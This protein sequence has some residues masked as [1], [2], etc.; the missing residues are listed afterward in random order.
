MGEVFASP[1]DLNVE[2]GEIEQPLKPMLRIATPVYDSAGR[3]RGIVLV[4]FFGQKVLERLA[5]AYEG[6]G[7]VLLLSGDGYFL[8]GYTAADEWRFMHPDQRGGT[9][10]DRYPEL[11]LQVQAADRGSGRADAGLFS[12][13]TLRPVP[14]ADTSSCRIRAGVCA[15][16]CDLR[17]R[18]VRLPDAPGQF[19]GGETVE[20]PLFR[21]PVHRPLPVGGVPRAGS[22][23]Y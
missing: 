7:N 17:Y 13:R 21:G 12:F 14:K 18:A 11:W 8:K 9:L 2:Q 22:S 5:S 16:R 20:F 19:G 23:P 15:Q 10:A 1:L 6:S 3:K 4:N